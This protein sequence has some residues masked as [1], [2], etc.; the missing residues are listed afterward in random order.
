MAVLGEIFR[1]AHERVMTMIYDKDVLNLDCAA[2]TARLVEF[3]RDYARTM[4]REG[5]VIGLSGGVDS[6]VSAELCVRAFG[7]D[8]VHGLILPE[9]DSNPISAEYGLRQAQKLG[10]RTE[11][12]DLTAVLQAFGTYERRDGLIREIFPDYDSS[13]KLKISLPPDLLAKDA[14]NFFTLTIAGADGRERSARLGKGSLNGI[15]ATTNTKQRMRMLELY[16]AAE[17]MNYF[18]CGTTNKTENVQGFF[19]KYGDGGVDIEPLAHLY[20]TQVF[21]MA[22]H[23]GVIEDIRKRKPSPDTYSFV[24]SD[25]EFF[26][27][28]PFYQLD[29]LLFAWERKVPVPSVMKVMGL[30]EDQVQRAYRDF[31]SKFHA[32]EH[33][34]QH[35][36]SPSET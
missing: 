24:V 14:L 20:K 2:E 34:R 17:R 12:I 11:Q 5:A 15:V 7:P 22:E 35:P 30:S 1:T 25:E 29:M 4:R 18:V 9:R 27:R 31:T 8:R 36:P 3:L 10:I 33:I 21:Q 6:A 16:F 26:F 13:Y 28:I 23:L 32:T 19:V